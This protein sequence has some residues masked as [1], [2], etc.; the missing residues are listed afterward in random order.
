MGGGE[1]F[2]GFAAAAAGGDPPVGIG[3][4]PPEPF[5]IGNWA[6][7]MR[8]PPLFLGDALSGLRG[9]SPQG[10]RGGGGVHSPQKTSLAFFSPVPGGVGGGF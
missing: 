10:A 5:F 7:L 3:V 9:V 8:F 1:F 4:G 6:G 2:G